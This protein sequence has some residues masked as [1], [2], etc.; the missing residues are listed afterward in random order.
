MG[1][2]AVLDAVERKNMFSLEGIEIESYG[3]TYQNP[4]INPL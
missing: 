1:P 3:I 4:R 2:R